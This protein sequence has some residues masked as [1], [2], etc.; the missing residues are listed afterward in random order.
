MI[1]LN[2]NDIINSTQI[3]TAIALVATVLII[4][5]LRP[6]SNKEKHHL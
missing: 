4:L 2:V 3:A 1:N 6:K 5:L